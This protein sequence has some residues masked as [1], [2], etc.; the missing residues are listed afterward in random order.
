[1][2]ADTDYKDNVLSITNEQVARD[3]R[4]GLL[5]SLGNVVAGEALPSDSTGPWGMVIAGSNR[6]H[7]S[8]AGFTS[9]PKPCSIVEVYDIKEDSFEEWE[10]NS[11][12]T[13]IGRTRTELRALATCACGRL[14]KHPVSMNIP[15]GELIYAVTRPE[16]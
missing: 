2:M 1:M 3:W 12:G 5:R 14:V 11:F 6:A 13:D 9:D 4:L 7:L 15:V 8:Y 10:H 16:S